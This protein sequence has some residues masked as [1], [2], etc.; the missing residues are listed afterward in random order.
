MSEAR[1]AAGLL[2]A[3]RA[4]S[5]TSIH[6]LAESV[7]RLRVIVDAADARQRVRG[8]VTPEEVRLRF[9]TPSGRGTR[10]TY[11]GRW[12]EQGGVRLEGAFEQV[13]A[14]RWLLHAVSVGLTLLLAA[15]AWAFL[16]EDAGAATRAS[17][18]ITAA[19]AILGFPFLVVALGSDREVEEIAI[20]KAI[21]TALED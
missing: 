5:F 16:T 8:E 19:L 2:V 6:S 14:T 3:H 15:T 17:L 1:R 4:Q 12:V 7:S 11:S 20:A 10:T 9:S 21:R 18:A 13:R